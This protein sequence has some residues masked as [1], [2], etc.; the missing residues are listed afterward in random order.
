MFDGLH[1]NKLRLVGWRNSE[2]SLYSILVAQ[3]V[4]KSA[5]QWG[6]EEGG[7]ADG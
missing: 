5:G 1:M 2:Q 3:L 4:K 7:H 6:S